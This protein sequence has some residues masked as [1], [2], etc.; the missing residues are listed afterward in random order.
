MIRKYFIFAVYFCFCYCESSTCSGRGKS[1]VT[2][3]S[4]G[5]TQPQPPPPRPTCGWQVVCDTPF[6]VLWHKLWYTNELASNQFVF[7]IWSLDFHHT[8]PG[9]FDAFGDGSGSITCSICVHLSS[10]TPTFTLLRPSV[11][12]M[13]DLQA[14]NPPG[15][16]H[17]AY[18][19]PVDTWVLS[20]DESVIS[21]SF[22]QILYFHSQS[23]M[24]HSPLS[25]GD[26]GFRKE[27]L[28]CM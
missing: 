24:T 16:G 13:G 12:M 14:W 23:L 26:N 11:K 20:I 28:I 8:C 6:Q 19:Q 9:F 18:L 10:Q 3:H 27:S 5:N 22:H 7:P 25:V 21:A 4:W 15:P 2:K 1:Q 17:P